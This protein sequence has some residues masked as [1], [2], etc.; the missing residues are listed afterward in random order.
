[1]ALVLGHQSAKAAN[2]N[3]IT[4]NKKRLI[5]SGEILQGEVGRCV[6]DLMPL[7][8]ILFDLDCD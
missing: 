8:L 3:D 6:E 7:R 4:P 2:G 5:Q 1:M